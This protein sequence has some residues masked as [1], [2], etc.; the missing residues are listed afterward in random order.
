LKKGIALLLIA[1]VFAGCGGKQPDPNWTA[2]EY[3]R[4]AKEK[5][6]DEDYFEAANDFVVVILRFAGSAIADSAQYYIACSHF[7]MDEYIISAA[8]FEKLISRM[9]QSPLV[10]DAQFMLAE[11]YYQ[12]S[13][14]AP[15]D[16]EFTIKALREFQTFVEEYPLHKQ[17]IDA[18]KKIAELREKLARKQWL[19]AELYRKMREFNSSLIYYD[20]IIEQYYDTDYAEQA[21]FGKALV[22]MDMKDFPKAKT[23]ILIFRDK[24]PDSELKES[25]EKNL[26]KITAQLEK[27]DKK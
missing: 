14:R 24:Y 12:M 3:F 8:E 1:A 2:E 13:P 18:E 21:V 27:Q 16:Q 20:V 23:Q 6:D 25:A 22:Y 17:R 10:P 5:Y 7:Y 11:S 4:Y 19:N 15:L 9:A 26:K